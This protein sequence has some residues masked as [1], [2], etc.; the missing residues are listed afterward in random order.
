MTA[1]VRIRRRDANAEPVWDVQQGRNVYPEPVTVWEG[2]ARVQ[3]TPQMERPAS[4]GDR[5]VVIVGATVSIPVDTP[6]VWITDEANVL[7]YRDPDAGDPHLL[8]R[9]LWVHEVRPGSML[10]QRDLVAHDIPP[11]SR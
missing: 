8:D 1:R 9:P 7:A 5:N 3:R 10:W 4:I 2:W 6:E 11:M